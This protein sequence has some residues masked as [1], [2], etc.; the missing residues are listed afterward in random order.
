MPIPKLKLF[1]M[2]HLKQL[3]GIFCIFRKIGL[4]VGEVVRLGESPLKWVIDGIERRRRWYGKSYVAS[5]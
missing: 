4:L 1:L 2:M 5:V 3:I